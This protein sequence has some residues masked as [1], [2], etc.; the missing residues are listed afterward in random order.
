MACPAI[1]SGA[2]RCLIHLARTSKRTAGRM[3]GRSCGGWGSYVTR[4]AAVVA[5]A[6]RNADDART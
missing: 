4:R 1:A 2:A 5:Q 6:I 3:A